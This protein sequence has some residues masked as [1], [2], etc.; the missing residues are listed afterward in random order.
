MTTVWKEYFYPDS[1]RDSVY[2]VSIPSPRG[3]IPISVGVQD[4]RVCVWFETD[5]QEPVVSSFTLSIVG[6]GFGKVPE[7]KRFLGTVI[8]GRYVWHVYA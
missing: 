6:T 5:P 2:E 3:S 4:G 7:G 1:A 8:D